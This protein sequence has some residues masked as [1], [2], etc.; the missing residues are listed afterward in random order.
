[1]NEFTDSLIASGFESLINIPTRITDYSAPCI[2][3][4][5]RNF[6]VECSSGVIEIEV[7]DNNAAFASLR[8]TKLK[9]D[10]HKR[11]Q[12]RDHSGQSLEKFRVSLWKR[13]ILLIS[14][15]IFNIL[16]SS[17]RKSFKC[18]SKNVRSEQS[19]PWFTRG[20][21]NCIN[22]NH[23]L[24]RLSRDSLHSIAY[25]TAYNA[26]LRKCLS[27]AKKFYYSDK[28]KQKQNDP[29]GTWKMINIILKPIQNDT[30]FI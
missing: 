15:N 5:Y 22:E 7:F 30:V 27:H 28:L 20:L 3:H 2:Y 14:L 16:E 8:I 4:I 1:M 12:F 13:L 25:Y 10:V 19:N 23:R 6:R 29:Q 9:L 26:T 18:R 21:L 17:Y 11:I 24:F